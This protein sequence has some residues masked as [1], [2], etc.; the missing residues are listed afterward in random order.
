[1]DAGGNI[2]LDANNNPVVTFQQGDPEW[3]GVL[4]HPDAPHGPNN[5]FIAR[6]AFIALPVGNSLDLNY[7][8]NQANNTA[9][10]VN[11]GF[12]RNQGVGAWEINLASFLADLNTNIWSPLPL[13]ANFYY[14]YN[15]PDNLTAN[16][17]IAFDD[18]RA[19]VAYRYNNYSLPSANSVLLNAPSTFPVNGLDNYSSGPLQTNLDY[20]RQ[21]FSPAVNTGVPWSG[22]DNTNH[23]FTLADLLDPHQVLA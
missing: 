15:E 8:H 12:A 9:L 22:A 23:F 1:M 13:P 20:S 2:L 19:L 14:S 17:G 11:D 7:I 6:Y 3:V 18:A 5:H 16:S 10:T 4:E 21:W